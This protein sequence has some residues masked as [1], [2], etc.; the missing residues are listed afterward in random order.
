MDL[1]N[2]Y[3]IY[4]PKVLRV[5][6]ESIYRMW[7]FGWATT[8]CNPGFAGCD[9]IFAARS[10]PGRGLDAW[11]VYKGDGRWD[12]SGDASS[13]VPVVSAGSVYFDAVHNGDPSVVYQG[14]SFWMA[15]SST[16]PGPCPPN[17]PCVDAGPGEA[18]VYCVHFAKSADG[19]TW[20]KAAA[21]PLL[22]APPGSRPKYP[23]LDPPFNGSYPYFARPSLM[24]DEGRWRLWF[25]Y[26]YP[27]GGMGHAECVGDPMDANCWKMTNA[28]ESPLI[29]GWPN[30]AVVKLKDGKYHAF[31]DP[32]GYYSEIEPRV[33]TSRQI[34]EAI[35]DDGI[36]WDVLD[37]IAPDKDAAAN[38]VPETFV[39]NDVL[40]LF[41][42]CPADPPSPEAKD[43]VY[44]RIRYMTREL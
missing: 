31:G 27:P 5:P 7:F 36:I 34:R 15:F 35:S 38:Q 41:Y 18:V 12:Q 42:A 26:L 14:G 43:W 21:P 44:P 40:H 20:S 13:W 11:E 4:N 8:V 22:H 6:G 1:L 25:D 33:F 17:G 9:A 3:N 10:L 37:Y 30:A 32:A 24:Y 28:L 39:E 19:L 2:G 16:G 23:A 29:P